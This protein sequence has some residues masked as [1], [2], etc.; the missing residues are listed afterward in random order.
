LELLREADVK[1]AFFCIGNRLAAHPGLAAQIVS[2][3]HLVENHS[4]T[5]SNATNVFT[6][7]RLRAELA[8]TQA[9]IE[10]AT[11]VVAHC[12]RPPMGLSNPRIF[13]VARALGLKVVGWS[14]RGLDTRV[15]DPEKIVRRIARKLKPGGIILLHDGNIPAERLVATVK[16]LLGRLR[17]LGYEVVRLDRILT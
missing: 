5:H 11:G 9:A 2:E 4:Y 1:A 15:T 10:Q 16:L 14:A 13:R 8:D 7:R 12:F 17:L 3:G 6:V